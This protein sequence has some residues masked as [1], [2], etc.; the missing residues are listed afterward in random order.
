MA[1]F[2]ARMAEMYGHKWTSSYG[3]TPTE[4]W[5]KA[6]FALSAEQI[7]TGLLKCLTNGE[8]WP[9]SAPEF[10]AM[11]R[12]ARREHAAMYLAVPMLPAPKCDPEKAAA[13]LAAARR[14]VAAS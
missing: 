8:A 12:P 5:S 13:A 2:W 3:E 6:L 10:V 14:I 9:P 4:L 7:R 11:C 1:K